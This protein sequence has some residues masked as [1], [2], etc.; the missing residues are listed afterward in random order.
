[1]ETDIVD[2]TVN[3]MMVLLTVDFLTLEREIELHWVLV[4][5]AIY[6]NFMIV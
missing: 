1:M 2:Y 6:H 5:Y 4:Q 3:D